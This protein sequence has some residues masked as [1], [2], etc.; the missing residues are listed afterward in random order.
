MLT[1]FQGTLFI[2][3]VPSSQCL[4]VICCVQRDPGE[5]L[6]Y[7]ICPTCFLRGAAQ[8]VVLFSCGDRLYAYICIVVYVSSVYSINSILL[9]LVILLCAVSY[10]SDMG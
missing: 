6:C 5:S 3:I 1:V 10:G 8:A 9:S 4:P 7:P 2:R